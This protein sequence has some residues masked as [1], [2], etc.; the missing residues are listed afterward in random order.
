MD[1]KFFYTKQLYLLKQ[2][3]DHL[4]E[5]DRVLLLL[6]IVVVLFFLWFF[7]IVKPIINSRNEKEQK[8]QKVLDQITIVTQKKKII[9]ILINNPGTVNTIMHFKELTTEIST[10]DKEISHYNKRYISERDLAKLLH[11]MLKQTMGVTIENFGTVIPIPAP[12]QTSTTTPKSPSVKTSVPPTLQTNHYRL[13]MRGTYFPVIKYLQRL[14]QLPWR[15]YWDKFDYTV[16]KYPEGLITVDFYTLKPKSAQ[17]II[18][19][20]QN[21]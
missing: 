2:K 11:D 12:P 4:S 19:Q 5:R 17:L 21:Q 1:L 13:I 18:K 15:L 9:E 14:E 8:V 16:T 3:I 6:I 10:L 20:G 7:A